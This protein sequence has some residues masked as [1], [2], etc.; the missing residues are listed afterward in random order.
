M[1]VAVFAGKVLQMFRQR[2]QRLLKPVEAEKLVSTSLNRFRYRT[3][4]LRILGFQRLLNLRFPVINASLSEETCDRLKS[5]LKPGDLLLKDDCRFPLSQISARIVQCYWIHSGIY[6]GNNQ[7]IDIGSRSYVAAVS[8]DDFLK[9]SKIAI[10]R[11]GYA[12]LADV[13]SAISFVKEQLGKPFNSKFDLGRSNSFYCTQLLY[14]ALKQ[15][16][17]PIQINVSKFFGKPVVLHS[18]IEK[19]AEIQL[20]DFASIGSWQRLCAHVPAYCALF[21]GAS[22]AWRIN[23]NFV[24]S[25]SLSALTALVLFNNRRLPG[26][27]KT[28]STNAN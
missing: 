5:Q 25:G 3:K 14:E 1:A 17:H 9:A 28:V 27:K 24:M 22:L 19:S 15:L 13:Q 6:V 18:D 8:L 4:R 20:V 16:P 21:A 7:V 10:Y 26:L 12:S 11:P 2:F 23:R